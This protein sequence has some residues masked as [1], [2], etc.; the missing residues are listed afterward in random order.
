MKDILSKHTR[1]LTFSY[2][3]GSTLYHKIALLNKEMRASLPN[4]GLLDQLKQLRSNHT[5]LKSW[6][7]ASKM[8]F[9]YAL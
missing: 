2:L 9:K 5:T 7:I 3:D 4:S 6:L 1:L 8:N